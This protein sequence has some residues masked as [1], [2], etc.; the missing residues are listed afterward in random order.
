MSKQLTRTFRRGALVVFA[1][2]SA[3]CAVGP[4]FK[5]QEFDAPQRFS[6][7][8]RAATQPAVPTDRE[9]WKA[10]GDPQLT[11]LVEQALA[12]NRNIRVAVANVDRANAL[13]GSAKWTQLPSVTLG[14][15][16][17]RERASEDQSYGFPR[18]HNAYRAGV[19]ISWELD[20]YGRVRRDVEARR[21]EVAASAQDITALQ[22]AVA[23]ETAA[24]YL[25]MRGLQERLRV[26]RANVDRLSQM[27]K[28][29]DA[30]LQAGRGTE[31]DSTRALAQL[32]TTTSRTPALELQLAT[33]QHRL[34]VLTG[35]PPAALIAELDP[36]RELPS[37]PPSIDPET[38]TQVLRRRPDVAAAEARLHAATARIGVASADLFPRLSFSGLI[39]TQAFSS[40]ALFKSSSESNHVFL[41]ID[42][43]FLDVGRVRSRIAASNADAAAQLASYQQT[44]LVALEETENALVR[45][46]RTR[47]EE[48]ELGKAARDSARSAELADARYRAGKIELF[49]FLSIERDLLAAQASFA[50]CRTRSAIAAVGLY[51]ALAGGWPTLLPKDHHKNA[52]ATGGPGA[53]EGGRS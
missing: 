44:V 12:A 47:S 43:T 14:A 20:L 17:G 7:D 28:V 4:D 29:V 8:E 52:S 32:A 10:F 33:A 26:L 41:G 19:D 46:A 21:A 23:A 53:A 11:A 30:R 24:T 18:S 36:P 15:E 39:G 1:M 48:Q 16:G 34:A 6:R 49:E 51:K 9:F 35:R 38:P 40:S 13:L 5:A 27:Y 25:E 31:M 22:V 3:G 50:D 42:W 37:L 45:Y 2:A